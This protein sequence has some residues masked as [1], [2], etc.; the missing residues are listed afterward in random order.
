MTE[1]KLCRSET[2]SRRC[3]LKRSEMSGR[4]SVGKNTHWSPVSKSCECYDYKLLLIRSRCASIWSK[5][6]DMPGWRVH[7][8]VKITH[9]SLNLLYQIVCSSYEH[10]MGFE[11]RQ[12]FLQSPS[13][14]LVWLPVFSRRGHSC[15]CLN[16]TYVLHFCPVSFFTIIQGSQGFHLCIARLAAQ[17]AKDDSLP[18]LIIREF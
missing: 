7:T 15:L 10:V 13:Y 17:K 6:D 18:G 14:I 11:G 1:C 12:I 8:E 16:L 3:S 5:S 9:C 4:L 2:I